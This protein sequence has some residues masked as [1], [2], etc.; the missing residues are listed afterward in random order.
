MRVELRRYVL[1]LICLTGIVFSG[2]RNGSHVFGETQSQKI[3]PSGKIID[4]STFLVYVPGTLDAHKTHPLVIALSPGGDARGMIDVWHNISEELQ[5]VILA[6]KTYH[7]GMELLTEIPRLFEE[8]VLNLDDVA[9]AV[10][11][12]RSKIIATGFSGGGMGSHMFAYYFPNV[13]SAIIVNTGK[14]HRYY[15]DY[16]DRFP[17]GKVAVF[18]ASPTDFRYAEMKEDRAL[19]DSLGWQTKWIEFEGGHSIAPQASYEQAAKWVE[20]QLQSK[21]H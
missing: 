14:I 16:K 8:L 2:C 4:Y 5:W 6:S 21:S 20:D 3:V 17:R 12:D 15:Y 19:L 1:F 9:R 18:L 11:I 13:I 10:P 7:N